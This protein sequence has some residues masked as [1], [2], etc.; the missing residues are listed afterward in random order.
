MSNFFLFLAAVKLQNT[1]II[2]FRAASSNEH[3]IEHKT[4]KQNWLFLPSGFK[5]FSTSG[6]SLFSHF[7]LL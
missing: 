6:L 7:S 3:S 2:S 1:E 5:R 4:L